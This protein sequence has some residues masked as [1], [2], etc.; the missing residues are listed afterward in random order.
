MP[1]NVAT[2]YVT[3]E[4]EETGKVLG[5]CGASH[6]SQNVATS[7]RQVKERCSRESP[8][9]CSMTGHRDQ[10]QG[11]GQDGG[12]EDAA[13]YD[14]LES[15]GSCTEFAVSSVAT[16]FLEDNVSRRNGPHSGGAVVRETRADC[17]V[18]EDPCLEGSVPL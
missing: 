9:G 2:A 11:E 3:T 18:G 12:D 4:A 10:C 5:R 16:Q 7:H 14:C 13:F 1:V 15:F 6:P 8:P 17:E